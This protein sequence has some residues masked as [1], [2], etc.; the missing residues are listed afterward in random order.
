MCAHQQVGSSMHLLQID[1]VLHM[2]AVAH[3]QG[4]VT[5]AKVQVVAVDLQP[6]GFRSIAAC[7]SGR[8]KL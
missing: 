4:V 2:M 6:A 7:E 3:A 5:C 1:G 8:T